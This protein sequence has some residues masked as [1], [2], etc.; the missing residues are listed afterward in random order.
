MTGSLVMCNA[1]PDPVAEA[2]EQKSA[3]ATPTDKDFR[4]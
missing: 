2:Q 1:I 4:Q 3:Q